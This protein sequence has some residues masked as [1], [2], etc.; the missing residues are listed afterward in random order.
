MS[1]KSVFTSNVQIITPIY[2]SYPDIDLLYNLWD[3]CAK[4]YCRQQSNFWI[5]GRYAPSQSIQTCR[6]RL[7]PSERSLLT[8]D[9]LSIQASQRRLLNLDDWVLFCCCGGESYGKSQGI[10]NARANWT[11]IVLWLECWWRGGSLFWKRLFESHSKLSSLRML[12]SH[13][14]PPYTAMYFNL[15]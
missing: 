14:P 12:F 1:F 8:H 13:S 15:D 10:I 5:G 11:P 6:L 3:C 9:H 7:L 4:E 2:A